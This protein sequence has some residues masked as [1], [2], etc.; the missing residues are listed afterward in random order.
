M[1]GQEYLS[2]LSQRLEEALQ[3]F[4]YDFF[5]LRLLPQEDG[6]SAR[7]ELRGQGV[8]G[9]PPQ[10]VGS[11]VLNINDVQQALSQALKFNLGREEAVQKALEDL[12]GSGS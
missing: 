4:E 11:L 1:A 9:D 12:F 7:M 5:S 3:D 8:K 10:R 2:L 6:V